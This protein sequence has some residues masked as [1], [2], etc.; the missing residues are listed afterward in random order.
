MKTIRLNKEGIERLK[1]IREEIQLTGKA[2]HCPDWDKHITEED[3]YS[4][5]CGICYKLFPRTTRK[6][7]CPCFLYNSK[8]LI[9]R[10]NEII[11]YN[12]LRGEENE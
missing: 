9:R 1:L 3:N 10:F 2:N 6:S 4:N 7:N 5:N 8:Y 11:K 12:E